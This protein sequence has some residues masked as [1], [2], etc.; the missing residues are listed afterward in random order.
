MSNRK[1]KVGVAGYGVV[2]QKRAQ[3]LQ[4]H[5]NFELVSIADIRIKNDLSMT[6][7]QDL[8]YN[9]IELEKSSKKNIHR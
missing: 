6:N 7:N 3:I 8:N 2:G 4:K 9:Y 1:L 5:P